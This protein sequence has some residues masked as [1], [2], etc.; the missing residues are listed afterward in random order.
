MV[1]Q[2]NGELKIKAEHIID[3]AYNRGKNDAKR[4]ISLSGEYERAYQRG[5]DDAWEAAKK[6]VLTVADGGLPN[7]TAYVIFGMWFY[8]VFRDLSVTE[9]IEKI[10]KYE[11]DRALR[12]DNCKHKDDQFSVCG[13]S[14]DGSECEAETTEAN[15]GECHRRYYCEASPDSCI[16]GKIAQTESEQVDDE[17]RVGDEVYLLDEH[18]PR[19]VTCITK[20]NGRN[21]LAVQFTK[22]G[23]LC[24]DDVRDL[25]KTGRH[26]DQIQEVLNALKEVQEC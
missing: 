17:I 11:Q 16:H 13:G 25:H 1:V 6:I 2:K 24:A 4:E 19:V 21:P 3:E 7:E 8:Q 12:C 10:R 15:C 23:E 5:L 18:F 14:E 22:S 9:A 26:F 20:K